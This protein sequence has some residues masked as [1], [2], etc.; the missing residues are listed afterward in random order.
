MGGKGI[1]GDE[2][3]RP[4][5]ITHTHTHTHWYDRNDGLS[6]RWRTRR[7]LAATDRT[8]F[9]ADSLKRYRSF[10]RLR[11]EIILFLLRDRRGKDRDEIYETPA[12]WIRNAENVSRRAYLRGRASALYSTGVR[13]MHRV[14]EGEGGDT[15]YRGYRTFT[16]GRR[17]RNAERDIS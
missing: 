17:W 2:T 5:G 15:F 3:F 14:R 7:R 6:D 9:I 16:L 8:R 1:E 4:A 12:W 10:A 13:W 11:I